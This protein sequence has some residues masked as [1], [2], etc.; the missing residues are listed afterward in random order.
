MYCFVVEI[1]LRMERVSLVVLGVR[2]ELF[3][4]AVIALVDFLPIPV[5]TVLS[6]ALPGVRDTLD[7]LATLEEV[8]GEMAAVP[9]VAFT[10]PLRREP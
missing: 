10:L 5:L 9:G 7:P 8:R 4:V 1:G 3:P 2:Y 6:Y